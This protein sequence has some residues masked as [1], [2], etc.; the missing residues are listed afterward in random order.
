[1]DKSLVVGNEHLKAVLFGPRLP[2]LR[3]AF[4]KQPWAPQ[5]QAVQIAKRD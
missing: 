1:M 3:D 5:S 2:H 4:P